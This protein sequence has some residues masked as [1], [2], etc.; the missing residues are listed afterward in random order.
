MAAVLVA[1]AFVSAVPAAFASDAEVAVDYTAKILSDASKK[2][3]AEPSESATVIAKTTA[4]DFNKH[5]VEILAEEYADGQDWAK[6][7]Y[8][9][10]DVWIQK[11]V[12]SVI[13]DVTTVAEP[14]KVIVDNSQGRDDGV[15]KVASWN[16]VDANFRETVQGAHW[17]GKIG[18]V[19]KIIQGS[20]ATWY[21]MTMDNYTNTDFYYLDAK[22]TQ[23]ISNIVSVDYTAQVVYDETRPA[24]G[25]GV[26]KDYPW[27]LSGNH[28]LCSDKEYNGANM[29]VTNEWTT[30][31]GLVWVGFWIGG[32]YC[33]MH[34]D[35]VVKI[36]DAQIVGD[37]VDLIDDAT[38][39]IEEPSLFINTE[40]SDNIVG[41]VYDFDK[42]LTDS[43]YTEW[44]RLTDSDYWV[45]DDQVVPLEPVPD[46]EPEVPVEVPV[47]Y[48]ASIW[49]YVWEDS[50]DVYTGLPSQGGQSV[51]YAP[52]FTH[53]L[54]TPI[55][56]TV[57]DGVTWVKFTA[58]DPK[59]GS[60]QGQTLWIE[61]NKGLNVSTTV[62]YDKMV[63]DPNYQYGFFTMPTV[64]SGRWIVAGHDLT[65]Q[66]VHVISE[67]KTIDN[68]TW[69]EV[70][71]TGYAQ[72]LWVNISALK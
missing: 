19:T 2:I 32:Q 63:I 52:S 64:F 3:Y 31:N 33:Y 7:E 20:T 5:D 23:P 16:F 29:E 18:N 24:E 62:S 61:K 71:V 22:A 45:A 41:G 46:P 27:G 40:G 57:I 58:S 1:G 4:T 55:S 30:A 21:Q 56:E 44:Y 65:G 39:Y 15:Y 60:L 26:Y 51:G 53:A 70:Q 10:A 50:V 47:N 11:N 43:N 28:F 8:K 66:T 67:W 14:F 9:G 35:G 69:A 42:I 6:F 13:A 12:L 34:K 54:V 36:A 37:S 25:D 49:Q 48:H 72:P 68:A 59:F 17:G 38:A